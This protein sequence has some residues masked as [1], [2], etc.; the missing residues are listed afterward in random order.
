MRME[1]ALRPSG[2]TCKGSADTRPSLPTALTLTTWPP[3][4]APSR[5]RPVLSSE[6][7]GKLSASGETATVRS[8]PSLPSIEYT[9]TEYG[10]DRDAAY[11]KRLSGLT[12]IGMTSLAA[13]TR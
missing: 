10:L 9:Y 7:K 11:K 3:Y 1:C 2:I 12:A 6:M 5:K 8:A 13:G 4:D